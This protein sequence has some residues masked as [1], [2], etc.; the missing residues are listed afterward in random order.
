MEKSI[1]RV[2]TGCRYRECCR[3]IIQGI[4]NIITLI[5]VYILFIIILY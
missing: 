3:E 4:K 2:I 1:S 5:I